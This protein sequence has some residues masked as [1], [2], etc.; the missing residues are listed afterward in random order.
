MRS[1][2]VVTVTAAA[3]A[4]AGSAG[5]ADMALKAPPP[6]PL[7]FSWTGFYLGG[8]GGCGVTNPTSVHAP[9]T[10]AEPTDVL[11]LHA[12]NGGGCFGGGQIGYNYQF[13]GN[14]VLGLEADAEGSWIKGQ[15]NVSEEEVVA[16][17]ELAHFDHTLQTFGTVRGRFG[18]AVSTPLAQWLPYITGGWAWGRNNLSL[19]AH[20]PTDAMSPTGAPVSYSNTASLSGWTAGAGLEIALSSN[21]SVKA[22][23]LHI[24]FASKTYN[25]W[26]ADDGTPPPAA[27]SLTTNVDLVKVGINYRFWG[28]GPYYG[29]Y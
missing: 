16:D 20:E 10:P 23:Y 13:T 25:A 2:V 12:D 21:W 11:N 5:A 3:L 4:A 19:T 7:V 14:W 29:P 28:Y 1:L 22:E 15:G 8:N 17:P 6:P 26:I 18:Y 27:L 9:I 24:G